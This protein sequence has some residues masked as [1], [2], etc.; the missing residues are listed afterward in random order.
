M[1]AADSS[2]WIDFLSDK[3]TS[4][5]SHLTE[6][7]TQGTLLIP[8]VVLVELLSFPRLDQQDAALIGTL[9]RLELSS[10][11]WERC[12]ENRKTL[13]AKGLKCRLGD[14]LIAQ[15]CIDQDIPLITEDEDFRHFEK[16]GLQRIG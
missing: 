12:A 5:A 9:P 6:A 7:L 3:K 1:I 15:N 16:F 4:G 14:I 13:L 10:G 11:Y 2:V 8:P